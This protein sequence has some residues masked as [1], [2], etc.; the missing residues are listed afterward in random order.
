MT[1]QT[2]YGASATSPFSTCPCNH[3]TIVC[4][5]PRRRA[6]QVQACFLCHIVQRGPEHLI[7]RYTASHNQRLHIWVAFFCPDRCS[8]TP[9]CQMC[10]SNTLKRCCDVSSD[11]QA[12]EIYSQTV[13]CLSA[14][15]SWGDE[16]TITAEKHVCRCCMPSD[17][18]CVVASP[19]SCLLSQ[20]LLQ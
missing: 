13:C 16:L 9:L 14:V 8:A 3:D 20:T 12:H 11:L 5:K 18:R 17:K 2:A 19:R 1:A 15:A 7:A 10:D 4:A 6:D